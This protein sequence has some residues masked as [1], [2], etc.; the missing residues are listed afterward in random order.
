MKL[1]ARS[2]ADSLSAARQSLAGA[3][4]KIVELEAARG[5][6]LLEADTIAEVQR[7]DS[8]LTTQH[9]AASIYRDRIVGLVDRQRQEERDRLEAEKAAAIADMGKRVSRRDA[10]GQ[11]LETALTKVREACAELSAADEAIFPAPS[12]SYLSTASM[13]PLCRRD[14]RYSDPMPR[15]VIGPVRAIADGAGA[16]LAEEIR[17]KGADLIAIMQAEPIAEPDDIDDDDTAAAA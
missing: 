8:E 1:F 13:A 7:I 3:E 17:Q 11:L 12:S 14:R 15:L 4:A 10:A 9:H 2:T 6:N 5:A 16:G